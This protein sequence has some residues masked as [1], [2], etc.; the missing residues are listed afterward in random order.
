MTGCMK[1]DFGED[2]YFYVTFL[3]VFCIL[4]KILF[5]GAI[6]GHCFI[7]NDK[8]NL[9]NYTIIILNLPAFDSCITCDN[10]HSSEFDIPMMVSKESV[11]ITF[12]LSLGL[13]KCSWHVV[14]SF[15]FCTSL[16]I[17]S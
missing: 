3:I 6:C 14:Q 4:C 11:F 5:E 1:L 9:L 12:S 2:F 15:S 10:R 17:S 8:L 7:I 13:L 16:Y